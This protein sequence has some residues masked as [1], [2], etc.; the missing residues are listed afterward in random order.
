MICCTKFI[1]E[2]FPATF[3]KALA[4]RCFH[5]LQQTKEAKVSKPLLSF[6]LNLLHSR[7][8]QDCRGR[9]EK[10]KTFPTRTPKI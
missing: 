4:F 10:T 5:S 8:H 7:H 1:T 2:N 6:L 3:T 9:E